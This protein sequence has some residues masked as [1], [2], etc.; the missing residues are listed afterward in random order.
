MDFQLPLLGIYPKKPKTRIQKNKYTPVFII[1]LFT[2]AKI[3]KQAK[4]LPIICLNYSSG[5]IVLEDNL[6]SSPAHLRGHQ[7]LCADC[8]MKSTPHPGLAHFFSVI[9]PTVPFTHSKLQP[10]ELFTGYL[11]SGLLSLKPSL[12]PGERKTLLFLL[13]PELIDHASWVALSCDN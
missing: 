12:T 6:G 13:V 3:A 9:F 8:R 2:I 10:T 4:Y 1:A 11:S 7:S 5:S